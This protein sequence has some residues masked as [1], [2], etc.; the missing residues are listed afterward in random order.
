[1]SDPFF[2]KAPMRGLIEIEGADRFDFLQRLITN[3]IK[4]LENQVAL[5]ACLLTPQGKFLHDFFISSGPDVLLLDCEGLDRAENL[6]ERLDK[7]KMRANV[8]ISVEPRSPIFIC[9]GTTPRPG[10]IDP[11]HEGLGWRS[12]V[13]PEDEGV[14]QEPFEVWDKLRIQL[15]IPD[16][17]RDAQLE[18]STVAELNIDRFNGVSYEKGCFV[19]QELTARMKHRGLAKK[20]L[21]PVAG[22]DLP[23]ANDEIKRDGKVIGIMRSSCNKTGL[24]LLK[25]EAKDLLDDHQIHLLG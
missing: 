14:L 8:R 3:D 13:K 11:R 2:V 17:S 10:Y 12:F 15:G 7:Y 22:E 18:K 23:A 24:A 5:Y 9:F 6:Y 19:G 1:M 21:Y 20:H 16:G 4:K 25:D